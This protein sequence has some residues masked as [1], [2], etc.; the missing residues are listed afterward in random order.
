MGPHA[1]LQQVSTRLTASH[2]SL[3]GAFEENQF[4]KVKEQKMVK[5]A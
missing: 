2:I 4:Y 5:D 1:G 3:C